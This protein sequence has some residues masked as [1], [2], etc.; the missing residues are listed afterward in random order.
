MS[1]E[2]A[3]HHQFIG[4]CGICGYV[5]QKLILE[6]AKR[7]AD[8]TNG[9]VTVHDLQYSLGLI[10]DVLY[11]MLPQEKPKDPVVA[12]VDADGPDINPYQ[13][14]T[15]RWQAFKWGYE[16]GARN[17]KERVDGI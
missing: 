1:C 4:T 15:A 16:A 12:N 8:G 10:I 7:D 3:S 14:G 2:N 17:E 11:S 13:Y 5:N 6:V 9:M